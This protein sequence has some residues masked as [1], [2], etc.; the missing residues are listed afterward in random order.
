MTDLG[1]DGQPAPQGGAPDALTGIHGPIHCAATQRGETLSETDRIQLNHFLDV[2]ADVVLAVA[3]RRFT[4]DQVT[5]TCE[6]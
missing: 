3:K 5:R 2:L 6:L 1:W 4:G